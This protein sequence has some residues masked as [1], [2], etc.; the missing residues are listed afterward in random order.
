MKQI[1][2]LDSKTIM[3]RVMKYIWVSQR[4][5]KE[6]IAKYIYGR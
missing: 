2:Y 5:R 6:D 4:E 1:L 3:N